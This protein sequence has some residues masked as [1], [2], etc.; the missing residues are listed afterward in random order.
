MALP[1]TLIHGVGGKLW[2]KGKRGKGEGI[3][4]RGE[5]MKR[6]RWKGSIRGRR[7]KKKEVEKVQDRMTEFLLSFLGFSFETVLVPVIC[8]KQF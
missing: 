1:S 8:S 2:L 5:E 3:N 6:K 4:G 7:R